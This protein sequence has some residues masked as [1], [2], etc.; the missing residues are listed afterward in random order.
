MQWYL[1]RILLGYIYGYS[2]PVLQT[3][4]WLSTIQCSL[5]KYNIL[6]HRPMVCSIWFHCSV[7]FL[8]SRISFILS[9]LSTFIL[10]LFLFMIPLILV[11]FYSFFL[12]SFML[13]LYISSFIET[14][15]NNVCKFG[16]H[17]LQFLT[18]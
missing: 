17:K 2:I 1:T 12:S 9:N 16:T 13:L 11:Y 5:S 15:S 14:I 4:S 7:F 6:C 10:C 3:A 18:M 8:S